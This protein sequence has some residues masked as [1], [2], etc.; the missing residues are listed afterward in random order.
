M[1]YLPSSAKGGREVCNEKAWWPL[2]TIYTKE[3]GCRLQQSSNES[4]LK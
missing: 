1:N 3:T 2:L 4:D